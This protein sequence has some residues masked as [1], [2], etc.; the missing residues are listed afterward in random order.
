MSRM[1]PSR[2]ASTSPRLGTVW[3]AASDRVPVVMS[4]MS[5]SALSNDTGRPRGVVRQVY[6]PPGRTLLGDLPADGF[7]RQAGANVLDGLR[8]VAR[9][10]GRVAAKL[11]Q[12]LPNKLL[13]LRGR[14]NGGGRVR[15]VHDPLSLVELV[16][17]AGQ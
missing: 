15:Q 1:W 8:Q 13:R 14:G 10:D 17:V 7:I 16:A 6:P 5:C 4:R 9:G 11:V 12:H 2:L 3:P